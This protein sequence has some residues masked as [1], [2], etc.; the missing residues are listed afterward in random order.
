M[1]G[2]MTGADLAR[3]VVRRWPNIRL[4]M[5]SGYTEATVLGKVKMPDDVRLL[6]K[7]YSNAD[8]ADAISGVLRDGGGPK[9]RVA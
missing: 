5:T 7:P 6:S 3:D 1:P 4:L 8:L 9:A 2:A